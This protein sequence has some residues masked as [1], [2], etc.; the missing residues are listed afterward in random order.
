MKRFLQLFGILILAFAMFAI[1][2]V[3]IPYTAPQ[4]QQPPVEEETDTEAPTPPIEIQEATLLHAVIEYGMP[5]TIINNEGPLYTY[6]RFMQGGAPTDNFI[7]EWADELIRSINAGFAS[8]YEN[9]DSIIGEVNIQFD[10]FMI[11][12]RYAGILQKGEYSYYLA[13]TPTDVV[14]TFNIDVSRNEFLAATEILDYSQSED[15][16]SLL[17]DRLLLEHPDTEGYSYTIDESWL[18]HLVIGHDGIIVVLERNMFLPEIFPTLEVTLPY[19]ELGSA[20]LI[21][22]LPPLE[23]APV[24][25]YIPDPIYVPDN[26]PTYEQGENIGEF[27]D[28]EGDNEEFGGYET[29][30]EENGEQGELPAADDEFDNDDLHINDEPVETVPSVPPQTGEVDP[31]GLMIAITLDDGPGVYTNA[32]LDLFEM[33]GVRVTFCSIGNLVNSQNGALARAVDIGSEVIGHSWDHRNLAKLTEENV[34]E[35]IMNT[36]D[37]IRAA[38]GTTVSMFRPPYGAVSDTMRQVAAELDLVIINW[39][40]DSKDWLIQDADAIYNIILEQVADGSIVL[41]HESGATLEAYRRLIPE[42]LSRGYQLVTVSELLYHRVG[43][44]TPGHVYFSG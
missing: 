9:D 33:Y 44:L 42:L 1:S 8:L 24:P 5:V 3:G 21:R 39:S 22:T 16:L 37:V 17:G 4:I 30:A 40:L 2:G 11:D 20:L 10:S 12:N 34:R 36:T 14:K 6:F 15:I 31:S 28:E 29:G 27:G 26:E 19:D 13:M 41:S 32:F 18:Y 7:A 35:Q 38:T 25:M 23:A 43:E